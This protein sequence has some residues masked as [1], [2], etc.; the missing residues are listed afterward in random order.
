MNQPW[1]S[2]QSNSDRRDSAESLD[3]WR[4]LGELVVG[5]HELT[6]L[7]QLVRLLQDTLVPVQPDDVFRIQLGNSLWAAS[8][9][10]LGRMPGQWDRIGRHWK[11]T[12]AAASGIS[13]AVGVATVVALAR[14]RASPS[15]AG[16][17]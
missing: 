17:L 6:S 3:L 7:A 11:L 4:E 16:R 2:F 8:Q 5:E 9:T 12:A 10:Q 14:W 13:V 1:L 15:H